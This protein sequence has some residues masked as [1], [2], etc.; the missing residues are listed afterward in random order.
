LC[1]FVPLCDYDFA[2]GW[3]EPSHLRVSSDRRVMNQ[4]PCLGC[5]VVRIIL[6]L[7]ILPKMRRARST[8]FFAE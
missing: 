4:L 8:V 6:P 3:V 2:G 5:G 7:M 1:I